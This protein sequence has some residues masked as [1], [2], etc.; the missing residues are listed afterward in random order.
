YAKAHMVREAFANQ[1]QELFSQVDLIACPSAPSAGLPVA[2]LPPDARALA[3]PNPLLR[4]TAPFNL[5]RNPTLS[6]PCGQAKTAAPPSLQL[7]G[8]RLGEAIILQAGAAFERAT[9]WGDQRPPISL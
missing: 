1:F 5:S 8:P 7:V 4:F 2:A 3:G 6:L 9:D